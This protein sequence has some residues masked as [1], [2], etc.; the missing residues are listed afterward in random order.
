MLIIR[1]L[2]EFKGKTIKSIESEEEDAYMMSFINIFFTDA[3]YLSLRLDWRGNEC[4]ISS[5]E[6][7][8]NP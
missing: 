1:N 8:A 2:K 3:T 6:L 5:Y 4:Y 7:E